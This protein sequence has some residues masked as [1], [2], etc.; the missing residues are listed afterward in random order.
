MLFLGPVSFRKRDARVAALIRKGAAT[1]DQ[2][3]EAQ[4]GEWPVKG[5]EKDTPRD[6]TVRFKGYF[7]GKRTPLGLPFT[8]AYVNPKTD[9]RSIHINRLTLNPATPALGILTSRMVYARLH[10]VITLALGVEL[11]H[12]EAIFLGI[13][14][15]SS[16]R[17]AIASSFNKLVAPSVC[18]IVGEEHIHV[19]QYKDGNDITARRAFKNDA[20]NV[21][22][23]RSP[24]DQFKTNTLQA[25][26]ALL[27]WMP[28]SHYA[29]DHELQA[30]LHNLM[31]RGY[32]A[33]GRIPANEDELFAAMADMGVIRPAIVNE[34]LADDGQKDVCK[35][36]NKKAQSSW[37]S[38][39]T[40]EMNVGLNS[41][42]SQDI[43][44]RFWK[45]YL[46]VLYADLLQKYGDS[47]G[48]E[49]MGYTGDLDIMGLPVRGA[50]SP[51][52][53]NPNKLVP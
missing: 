40:G 6:D 47:K 51:L 8:M 5:L 30:R 52:E 36:F 24:F 3:F 42:R 33:W 49:R 50:P 53:F 35:I 46:P 7:A 21:L 22:N 19:M 45:D 27:T 25:I 13:S 23:N 48:L 29:Q 38:P 17:F 20:E 44:H 34:Y 12:F 11:R 39:P 16:Y 9:D 15:M 43:L 18:D 2:L 41:F 28:R 26:D 1:D 31:V 32:K 10:D 14:L 37:F 4:F